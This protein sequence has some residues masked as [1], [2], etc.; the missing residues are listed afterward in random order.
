MAD[1]STLTSVGLGKWPFGNVTA[2]ADECNDM[3]MVAGL[4]FIACV[5]TAH[6]IQ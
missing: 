4:P 2:V 6:Q 3:V 5:C 1:R